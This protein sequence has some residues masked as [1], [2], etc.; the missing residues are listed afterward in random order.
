MRTDH[1]ALLK[2]V[3]EKRKPVAQ[4]PQKKLPPFM[5]KKEDDP[6]RQV[7]SDA[8]KRRLAAMAG[9]KKPEK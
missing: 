7:K 9:G 2:E 4:I 6:K 8:A 3:Y 5:A 1:Q